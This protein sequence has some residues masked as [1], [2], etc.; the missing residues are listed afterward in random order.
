MLKLKENIKKDDSIGD[1]LRFWRQLKRISQMDLALDTGISSKHLSFV[2]TGR[3]QPSRDLVLKLAQSLNVPLRHRNV[4]LRAAGFAPEFDEEPFDGQKMAIVRQALTRMIKMHEPYPALVIDTTYKILMT[5]SGYD[6]II[7]FY[8]G[9]NAQ[10]KYDNVYRF[11]FAEDGLRQYIKDWPVIEQFM[12]GR[13]WEEAV[14]TQNKELFTLYEDISQL[15]TSNHPIS[16]QMDHNLPIM[17]LTL[18]KDSMKTSFFTTITTLGTP[19]DLTTQELRIESLFP[20]DDE[21]KKIF[22]L[23]LYSQDIRSKR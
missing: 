20:A 18:E 10:K 4:F 16:F 23:G 13:L 7:K 14:S 19:L 12:I 2:E 11:T 9:E 17:S 15:K 6:Q 22:Q 21:T 3:S 1:I 5:N 8:L